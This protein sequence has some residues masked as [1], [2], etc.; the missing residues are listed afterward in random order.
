[1]ICTIVRPAID[2]F[3][4]T[5]SQAPSYAS[6]KLRLTD[7]LTYSL[8]GVKC[9]AT[10]VAKNSGALF[11]CEQTYSCP[12]RSVHHCIFAQL[13]PV[14]RKSSW[15]R[16]Y[17]RNWVTRNFCQLISIS[18][19]LDIVLLFFVAKQLINCFAFYATSVS[20]TFNTYFRLVIIA[21]FVK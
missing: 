15:S 5:S 7:L 18:L 10:S 19:Y 12:F 1:M 14:H 21:I 17:D 2:K 9:R 13:C 16:L 8:T 4:R 20:A 11:A 6:P 3:N